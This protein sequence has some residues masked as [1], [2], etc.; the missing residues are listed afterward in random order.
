MHSKTTAVGFLAVLCTM[1]GV[2]CASDSA[3]PTAERVSLKGALW[4]LPPAYEFPVS[5]G[6]HLSLEVGVMPSLY[7]MDGHFVEMFGPRLGAF[8]YPTGK[9]EGIAL[10][11]G[12]GEIAEIGLWGVWRAG[13]ASFSSRRALSV[14]V[15]IGAVAAG[16]RHGL[17]GG[18]PVLGAAVGIT[19]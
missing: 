12:L 3:A 4:V 7:V 13:S 14:R 11:A 19:F 8:F 16:T 6:G 1:G 15:G 10:Y 17:V 18:G 2:C 9:L 5:R